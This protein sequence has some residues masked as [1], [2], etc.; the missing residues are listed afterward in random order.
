MDAQDTKKCPFC[1]ETIKKEAVVCRFCGR[2]LPKAAATPVYKPDPAPT[3]AP[4]EQKVSPIMAVVLLVMISICLY[5]VFSKLGGGGSRGAK[6]TSGPTKIDA[7]LICEQFVENQLKAPST[8]K[9]QNSYDAKVSVSNG[10]YTVTSYVDSQNGFGAMIR[11]T[12]VCT[13]TYLGSDKWHLV[14]LS[15]NP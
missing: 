3:T 12:Y 14:D 7:A 1:A 15:T 2:E 4:T 6:P 11:T 9:F 10:E 13:V 8:A 5:A